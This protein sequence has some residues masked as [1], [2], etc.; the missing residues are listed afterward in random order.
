MNTKRL[1][2]GMAMVTLAWSLP[3]YAMEHVISEGDGSRFDEQSDAASR[4][5]DVLAEERLRARAD[6]SAAMTRLLLRQ[7]AELEDPKK[8]VSKSVNEVELKPIKARTDMITRHETEKTALRNKLISKYREQSRNY[9]TLHNA[10]QSLDLNMILNNLDRLPELF[11]S[12]SLDDGASDV[13]KQELASR[14]QQK[15]TK[16]IADGEQRLRGNMSPTQFAIYNRYI[17]SIK[18]VRTLEDFSKANTDFIA[19]SAQLGPE[20]V[21]LARVVV[22]T[23]EQERRNFEIKVTI[24]TIG[25]FVGVAVV[26]LLLDKF[27]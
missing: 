16:I 8:A 1:L 15:M 27:A 5:A 4:S 21:E 19:A 26:G 3:M 25:L 23:A 2:L 17:E 10:I 13:E 18:S 14:F 6:T 24:G 12:F 11:E 20:S 22:N 7:K 9:T